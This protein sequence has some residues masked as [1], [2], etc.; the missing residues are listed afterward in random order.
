[1]SLICTCN[2]CSVLLLSTTGFI[3]N[4]VT[5][6]D[7]SYNVIVASFDYVLNWQVL[8]LLIIK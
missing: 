7:P 3:L 5:I 8:N 2:H 6:V 4:E 1:M